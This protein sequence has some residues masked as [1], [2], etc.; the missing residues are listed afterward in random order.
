MALGPPRPYSRGRVYRPVVGRRQ[1]RRGVPPTTEAPPSPLKST[2]KHRT[3]PTLSSSSDSRRCPGLID[4]PELQHR[5][6]DIAARLN[7]L[8]AKRDSL[9]AERTALAHGN[10]LRRRITPEFPQPVS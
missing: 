6:G 3:P 2:R 5:S 4:L 1:A 9:A 7:G 10:L 8:Q